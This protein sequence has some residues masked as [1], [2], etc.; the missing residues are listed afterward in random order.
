MS[1]PSPQKE[2][3]KNLD[4]VQYQLS[5]GIKILTDKVFAISKS[6]IQERILSSDQIR[7]KIKG[8]F[9]PLLKEIGYN[10]VDLIAIQVARA[11]IPVVEGKPP[12]PNVEVLVGDA[13]LVEKFDS[14]GNP[15]QG[16]N[17]PFRTWT[18]NQNLKIRIVNRYY[19]QDCDEDNDFEGDQILTIEYRNL[20][21]ILGDAPID[22]SENKKIKQKVI[23]LIKLTKSPKEGESR[24]E[25]ELKLKFEIAITATE[26]ARKVIEYYKDTDRGDEINLTYIPVLAAGESIG[27]AAILSHNALPDELISL[28]KLAV[29]LVLNQIKNNDESSSS[30]LTLPP[31]KVATMQINRL[32]HDVRK[33]VQQVEDIIDSIIEEKIEQNGNELTPKKIADDLQFLSKRVKDLNAIINTGP[34][35]SLQKLKEEARSE[36]AED[37]LVELIEDAIYFWKERKDKQIDFKK[38]INI[39]GKRMICDKNVMVK[40]PRY[41]LLEVLENLVANAYRFAQKEVVVT[42]NC[43][44]EGKKS[45][46]TF[47]IK[48]DGE[49]SVDIE[50]L[51]KTLYL[52]YYIDRGSKSGI[53][54]RVSQFIVKDILEGESIQL[55]ATPDSGFESKFTIAADFYIR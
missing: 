6:D 17:Y 1:K 18:K 26:Y 11:F 43:K 38:Y 30:A 47:S 54:L 55:K 21:T 8:V 19:L 53:G 51:R 27:G 20:L 5:E 31:I 33:T 13:K 29:S 9:E 16:K 46:I 41:L 4:K 45:D 24:T 35:T 49:Y 34:G 3:T 14:E 50:N 12:E 37:N 39:D 10:L 23:N 25:S 36:I 32:A 44:S 7:E 48:D 42:A 40:V 52:P 15:Y 28:F 22:G 2:H